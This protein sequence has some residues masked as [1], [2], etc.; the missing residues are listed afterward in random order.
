ML[1]IEKRDNDRWCEYILFR[2][3]VRTAYAR[4]TRGSGPA[5]TDTE[6]QL[7]RFEIPLFPISAGL[8]VTYG[9]R[10]AEEDVPA[11][12]RLPSQFRHPGVRGHYYHVRFSFSYLHHALPNS[13]A[14]QSQI[15]AT[16]FPSNL[17]I[18]AVAVPVSPTIS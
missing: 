15:P 1:D 11:K 8:D 4:L 2:G 5:I 10:L 6:L 17:S 7:G 14:Y 12:Y 16:D 18:L 13:D 3:L 9:N